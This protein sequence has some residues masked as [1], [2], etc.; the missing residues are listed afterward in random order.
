MRRGRERERWIV[1][2][3]GVRELTGP[4]RGRR[5]RR[6]R[7]ARQGVCCFALRLNV[8]SVFVADAVDQRRDSR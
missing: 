1:L 6:T 3:Q 2:H 5:A 8:L 7:M 4:R